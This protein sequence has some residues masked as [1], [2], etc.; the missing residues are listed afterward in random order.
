MHIQGLID[1]G[2][3]LAGVG[4][5]GQ[6]DIEG[7]GFFRQADFQGPG[8]IILMTGGYRDRHEKKNDQAAPPIHAAHAQARFRRG[9]WLIALTFFSMKSTTFNSRRSLFNR[10]IRGIP[11]GLTQLT[12]TSLPAMISMPTK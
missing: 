6:P 2:K 8:A 11:P 4:V 10:L 1:Q 9:G 3:H 12:S 7:A 5:A